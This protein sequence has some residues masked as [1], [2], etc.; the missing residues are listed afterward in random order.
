MLA[1][2]VTIVTP[3]PVAMSDR[4][5]DACGAQARYHHQPAF[6]TA[7]R[8]TETL[9]A[10]VLRTRHEVVLLPAEAIGGLE[11][12]AQALVCPGTP[13]LNLVSGVF[14][15]G[16]SKLLKTL[17]A[18]LH[19]L[20]A[21]YD[22]VVAPDAVARYLDEHPGIK[23]LVMTHCETPSGTLADCGTIGPIA[24]DRGV[25]TLVD[26]VSSVG[27][28]EFDTDRWGIDVAV[29]GPQKCLA[30]PTGYSLIAVSDPAWAMMEQNSCAPHRYLSLPGWRA[31]R[32]QGSFAFT[33]FAGALY[34][35]Q[36]ACEQFLE[37]GHYTVFDR[38]RRAADIFRAGITAMGLPQWPRT[39]GIAAP[40]VTAIRVPDSITP[41]SIQ[42]LALQRC[43]VQISLGYG[44]GPIIRVGH[45]GEALYGLVPVDAV[46]A[47]GHALAKL[48]FLDPDRVGD[49]VTA[50]LQ[51][52][53]SVPGPRDVSPPLPFQADAWP[54]G[55]LRSQL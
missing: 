13:V 53:D 17:G 51:E 44:A 49:G 43:G 45:M 15:A 34:G 10:K 29:T 46:I 33:P 2:R 54:V 50:A 41:G 26:C 5:R 47:V 38:T 52:M 27:G 28:V 24:R 36:A 7:F 18:D 25:L 32:R 1:D 3:G 9:V 55:R 19:E 42:D 16:M 48:K 14:G 20:T 31:H 37:D 39:P 4:V 35:L 40:C 23:L 21:A 30:G 8:D 6:R 12:A 11:A 22:D